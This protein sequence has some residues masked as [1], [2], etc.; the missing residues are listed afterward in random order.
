MY[1]DNI[2]FI[3]AIISIVFFIAKILTAL[4]FRF[5]ETLNPTGNDKFFI[6]MNILENDVEGF[7]ALF[8][9][10]YLIFHSFFNKRK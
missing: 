6:Q 3:A 8:I 1:L 7:I 10:L 2:F 9:S 4:R 5:I